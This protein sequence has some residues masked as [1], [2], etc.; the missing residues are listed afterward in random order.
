MTYND[1]AVEFEFSLFIYL[2][3]FKFNLFIIP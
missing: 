1:K 2:R 3:N